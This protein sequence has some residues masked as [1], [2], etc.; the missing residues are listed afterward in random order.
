MRR[1]ILL[2]AHLVGCGLGP[3]PDTFAPTSGDGI[4]PWS[5]LGAALVCDGDR[6]FGPPASATGGLCVSTA[7]S[8]T[9]CETDDQCASRESC[10][11]G[12][13]TVAY[14]AS[15]VDC[16]APRTCNF[17][18]HRCDL[19]CSS[20]AQC[21][22]G[23]ECVG[24]VCRGRCSTDEDCQFGEV[25]DSNHV[26]IG[27]DCANNGGCLSGERCDIQREPRQVLEPGPV[28]DFGAPIV[29]YLDLALPATPDARAIYRAFSTDGVHF[30]L[31]P[32]TPVI[33]DPA[34]ARAPSPVLDGGQLYLYFEQG[35]GAAL[36]V[37]TS[38]DGVAFDPPITVLSGSSKVLHAPSAVHAGGSVALYYQAGDGT[39]GIGLATGTPAAR[40]VDPGIVLAPAAVE[41]GTGAPGTAFWVQIQ[42]VQS[43]HAVLAGDVIKL[44][45]S[46][47]GHESADASKY[48][49][50]EAIPPN[51]SIGYAAAETPAPQMLSVWPYGPVFDRVDA[52]FD[53]HDELGPA[54]VDAG[55]DRFLL[56][57][58]DAQGTQLGRLGVLGSGATGR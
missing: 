44:F 21:A 58:I 18:Q 25:C 2:A 14:C 33:T 19:P 7:A 50:G 35:D 48:G 34:G 4:A 42:R 26:C 10:V 5:E 47:F 51:F 46:A 22:S 23:E 41:V 29:L 40:L 37:A 32:T 56:Y 28:A 27:D 39:A 15:E 20:A 45:Y 31:D 12:R 6:A 43:P 9:S 52:F 13:C 17:A 24:S 30:R 53:H 36:R 57:Y 1:T 49:T 11:C 54:E 3:V 55:D 8:P 16:A 38:S